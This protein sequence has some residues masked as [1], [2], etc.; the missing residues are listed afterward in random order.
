MTRQIKLIKKRPQRT[1]NFTDPCYQLAFK[2]TC[3]LSISKIIP[4]TT[5]Q[6]FIVM[7]HII[8]TDKINLHKK[9]TKKSFVNVLWPK[10]LEAWERCQTKMQWRRP[11]LYT[12]VWSAGILCLCL[13]DFTNTPVIQNILFVFGTE[14]LWYTIALKSTCSTFW[15]QL[16]WSLL[17][18][19]PALAFMHLRLCVY[20]Y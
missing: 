19:L 16:F 9:K 8:M 2:I 12:S 20:A 3:C 18:L 17:T 1:R 13:F 6:C 11:T 10:T 14:C 7:E 5:N 15:S 4:L